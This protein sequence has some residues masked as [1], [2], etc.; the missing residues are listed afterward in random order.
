M[1]C[2]FCLFFCD[3]DGDE[4]NYCRQLSAGN[5]HHSRYEDDDMCGEFQGSHEY[6]PIMKRRASEVAAKLR[7][8]RSSSG[9]D[10]GF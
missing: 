6:R 9:Q 3:P 2:G 7:M 5:F 10:P 8:G 1:R 4:D